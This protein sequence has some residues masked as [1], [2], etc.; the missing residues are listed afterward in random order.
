M[1]AAGRDITY[2]FDSYHP[3]T[4]KPEKG[5]SASASPAIAAIRSSPLRCPASLWICPV[6]AKFEIGRVTNTE[7]PPYKPDSGFYKA[8]CKRLDKY[9]KEKNLNPKVRQA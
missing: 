9:F 5:E 8:L 4:D 7:F 3:F 2:A 1:L 6:L